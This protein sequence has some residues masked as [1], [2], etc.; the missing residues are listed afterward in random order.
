MMFDDIAFHPSNPDPGKIV[1]E[2]NGTDVYGG[3]VKDYTGTSVTPKVFLSVLKGDR[4]VGSSS[5]P[6]LLGCG[7]PWHRQG[8][9]QWT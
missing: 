8:P 7:G 6:S 1:N 4:Q 3:V 5:P 2:V 9:G